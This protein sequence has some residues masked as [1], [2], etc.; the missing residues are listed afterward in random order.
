MHVKYHVKKDVKTQMNVKAFPMH[1]KYHVKKDVKLEIS[2][3][4][5]M[6][7]SVYISVGTLIRIHCRIYI[8]KQ[9]YFL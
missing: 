5:V 2:C 4:N 7:Y 9:I 6:N 3:E 8:W 1:V